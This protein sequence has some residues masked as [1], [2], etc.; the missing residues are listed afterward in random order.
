MGRRGELLGTQE[1]RVLPSP[2]RF[3]APQLVAELSSSAIDE[4]PTFTGDLL[5]VCFMSNR[6]G[7]K[8]IWTSHRAVATDAW[9]PPVR[10]AE[11]SS[12]VR[13]LGAGPHPG[14]ARHLVRDGSRTAA[15]RSSGARRGQTRSAAVGAPLGRARV[16]QQRRRSV[17]GR[18]R[19]R[20]QRCTSPPNRPGAAGYDIYVSARPAVNAAWGMPAPAPG[21]VNTADDEADPFIADGGLLLFV[22]RVGSTN[23]GEHLLGG[24]SVHDRGLVAGRPAGR[25]QFPLVRLRRRPVARP[26][27]HHVLV[28]AHR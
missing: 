8:D 6:A 4:D 20:A 11:L 14:W 3:S 19:G 28:D 5:E 25:R 24:A 1:A 16:G 22:T 18:R 7:T 13:R 23:A 15:A 27:L 26:Q 12:P 17:P 9:A 2:P 10:V 21:A